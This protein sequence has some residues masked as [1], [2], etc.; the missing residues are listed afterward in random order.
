MSFGKS[1]KWNKKAVDDAVKYAEEKGVLLVHAAG[2]DNENNDL[3]EN[4]PNKYFETPESIAYEKS[5]RRS[6]SLIPII[7]PDVPTGGPYDRNRRT[8]PA[9]FKKP[10]ID[11]TKFGFAHASNW[12]EVGAS[13]YA[14]DPNLKATFSNYGKHTVDV[15]APGFMINSTVPGSKY[16]EFDGTSMASPV[17]SGLA[18]LI[19]SYYPEL[20]P[21]EVRDIIMKSVSKVDIKVKHKNEKGES[22]R[23]LFSDLCVSGGVV[24]AYQALMLAEKYK[25]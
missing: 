21:S 20:K 19:L 7:K 6:T 14:N 3:S 13:A 16:K 1:F 9:S 17:V 8:P 22:S 11:T 2:N 25:N 15:F 18:A 12:I 23:V 5:H 4:Y 24:N 10:P